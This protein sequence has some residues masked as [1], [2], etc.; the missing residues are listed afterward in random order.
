MKKNLLLTGSIIFFAFARLNAA[1]VSVADAQNIAINFYKLTYANE[2]GHRNL[3][4]EVKYKQTEA[5]NTVDFYVF[6][7]TPVNGFVIV[8]ADDAVMPVIA[9]SNEAYFQL[10]FANSGL[11]NWINKTAGQIHQ[12]V[13][14]H[15]SA[16]NRITV[17]W[18]AYRQGRA[19][20]SEKSNGV[21]PLCATT[22]NQMPYYNEF[23]PINPNDGQRS[24]TGCVA[25]AMAQIMKY[26]N[27]PATGTGSFSY[28]DDNA[29]GYQNNIGTLSAN[30]GATTYQWT[31]MPNAINTNNTPIGTLMYH[32]GVSVAMDYSDG[33][34]GAWVLQN[35]ANAAFGYAGAPC[36]QHSYIT[37]FSYNPATIQGVYQ[38]SYTGT[39]WNNLL[40]NE[41]NSGRVV[42]Y[43]GDDPYAGGH[44]W[45]CDGYDV[46]NNFHMNWGW[47]GAANGW[48]STT[49][50]SA[51][52][53]TFDYDDEALIGIEP[54]HPVVDTTCSVAASFAYQNEGGS[55]IQ[56]T[57]T[58]TSNPAHA[59]TSNWTFYNG[60]G[61]FATSTQANPLITFTGHS[62]YSATLLIVDTFYGGCHDSVNQVVDFNPNTV[63]V[64]F[65][66]G[67]TKP[68]GASISSNYANINF[69]FTS[70]YEFFDAHWTNGGSPTESR[71]LMRFDF[72]QIP[73]GSVIVSAGLNLYTDTASNQGYVNQPTYGSDNA[74]NLL[75]VTSPWDPATVTWS[76]QP[77]FSTTNEVLLAQ[78][79]N[80]NESY[81]NIDI[82]AMVQAWVANPATN[83]GMMLKMIDQ[84]YYNDMLFCSPSNAATYRWPKLEVCFIPPNPCH[85]SASFVQQNLGAGQVRF[86]N[87]ST[88]N[89]SYTTQ[90]YFYN[91]GGQ[92]GSST[93]TNPTET[94]TG[95]QPYS[96]TLIITDSICA[97]TVTQVINLNNCV[98]Y[99]QTNA[100]TGA[101]IAADYPNQ[102]FDFTTYYEF[103]DAQWTVNGT[104]YEARSLMKYDLSQIPVASNIL[105][106]SLSLYTDTASHQGYVGQP[107]YGTENASLLH[108][109]TSPWD[110]ATVTWNA[111]PTFSNTSVVSLPQSTN[112]NEDYLNL[113]VTSFVQAWVNNPS[114]NYGMLLKMIGTYYYN[115][116]LFCSSGNADSS[117]WP[118]LEICYQVASPCH[119]SASF[120]QQNLGNGQAQFTN[121]SSLSANTSVSWTFYNNT[122]PFTTST[123]LNPV[124]TFTGLPPYSATLQI[125]D[126]VTGCRDTLQQPVD[127]ATCITYVLATGAPVASNYTTNFSYATGYSEFLADQWTNGGTPCEGRGLIQYDL[128]GIPAGSTVIAAQLN[129]YA[130]TMNA[131]NGYLDQPTYGTSNACNLKQIT[132]AWDP[133]TV[134]WSNQPTTTTTNEVTLAQSTSLTENYL[135]IDVSNFAQSWV[136]NPA[137]N[138]GMMLQMITQNHY[139]S[140]IFCSPAHADES[141]HPT[142][143]VCYY[144]SPSGCY[145]RDTFT[146][147][148]ISA[149][150]VQFTNLST[151][152][153]GFTSN[154]IF[155]NGNGQFYQ[156]TQVNPLVVFTGPAPYYALL[157]I[158]DS[159]SRGCLDSMGMPILNITTGIAEPGNIAGDLSI[160]PNPNNGN[161]FNVLLPG[162]FSAQTT[163]LKVFDM[164]GR[165]VPVS[166]LDRFADHFRISMGEYCATGVYTLVINNLSRQRCGKLVVVR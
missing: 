95:S 64:T 116:M 33:G 109:V 43:A 105:S 166:A 81:L 53:Y 124:V 132:S 163:E 5:D 160:F 121:T 133:S 83:Y 114:T 13:V 135:N 48:Y 79:T 120:T 85:A 115:D 27:Y 57:N 146:Y 49:N 8:S 74:S 32:C 125:T 66:N 2:V 102:G 35:D 103:F 154:W 93:L 76:T 31:L 119:L 99:Q 90:W 75:V 138:Y 70:Y 24:V 100:A 12:T 80:A 30:F 122:G 68:T 71:S 159:V 9:Y 59:F 72:S 69:D 73:A 139:N 104:P 129:L 112:A 147:Q 21:G 82:S 107:T 47:G 98:T 106:A 144:N 136:S 89:T 151:A 54:L 34:S 111:Q 50:L 87:T 58:S 40:E 77:T 67:A 91:A 44:T 110:P 157:N 78:S 148:N 36:A 22:W 11:A 149:D 127:I 161:L 51:G 41:M 94:F 150:S 88:D 96:A 62:P 45:V 108:L 162:G 7:I 123:V 140:L 134:V 164:L 10:N 46:N 143:D 128:S 23:C 14:Q 17:A 145:I 1:T 55:A 117:K 153:Q 118:K 15:L 16:D 158:T 25:T 42:Q 156:S 28:V 126:S 155:Y 52:G 20:A 4:A 142:L 92:I 3:S 152:S 131:N 29:H 84:N 130:D 63:C 65:Q 38:N 6:D 97:D 39:Q 56:F 60:A 101:A 113:D 137:G 141:K 37:Y 26:W 86:T 18:T 165:E 19:P 61:Q